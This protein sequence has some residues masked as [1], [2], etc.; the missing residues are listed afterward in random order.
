VNRGYGKGEYKFSYCLVDMEEPYLVENHLIC[1]E[2]K[3]S[4]E[5]REILRGRYE[6]VMRSFEDKRTEE[7]INLYFENNAINTTELQY[8]LPIYI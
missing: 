2:S 3:D 1:I 5:D 8:I 7:F 4:G 6:K